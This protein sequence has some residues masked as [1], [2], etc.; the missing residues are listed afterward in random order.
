MLEC[1]ISAEWRN[2]MSLCQILVAR[3]APAGHVGTGTFL[4]DLAC[5]GLKNGFL[6]RFRSP[7]DY[8]SSL[9]TKLLERQQLLSCDIVL[10]AKVLDEGMKYA[11]ELGFPPERAGRKALKILGD[12]DPGGC[13]ETVPL[14]G[15]DG[16]PCFIAGP[17]DNVPRIM[18]TLRR[19]VG[20]DGFHFVAPESPL[21][22]GF[23]D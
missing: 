9:R 3:Q 8:Q 15:E 23:V 10:A 13:T 1:L 6:S 17:R 4:V 18:A 21:P 12:I 20:R 11:K 2:T 5:L 19:S 22:P 16:R 14:G 7:L